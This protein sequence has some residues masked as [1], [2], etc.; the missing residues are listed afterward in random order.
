MPE[1]TDPVTRRLRKIRSTSGDSC[2]FLNW[3]I[4]EYM[5]DPMR[6]ECSI[7]SKSCFRWENMP[8]WGNTDPMRR[9]YSQ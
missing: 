4:C 9:R 1:K 5:K 8:D 7:L 6:S 3:M 2:I